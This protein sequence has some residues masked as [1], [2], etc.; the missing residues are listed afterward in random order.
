M[1]I[2]PHDNFM[3]YTRSQKELINRKLRDK[4]IDNNM[5]GGLEK[6][7]KRKLVPIMEK[8]YPKPK[9]K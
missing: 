9:W 5:P 3:V 6:R 1:K 2:N 7:K 4:N 8:L